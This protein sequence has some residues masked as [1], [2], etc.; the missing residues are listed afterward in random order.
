MSLRQYA[1]LAALCLGLGGWLLVTGG[2]GFGGGVSVGA[3][4]GLVGLAS[5]FL[6]LRKY[7]AARL[8]YDVE[9]WRAQQRTLAGRFW[10]SIALV[11]VAGGVL[12]ALFLAT[13]AAWVAGLVAGLTGL[14]ALLLLGRLTGQ[15]GK[16]F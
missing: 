7:V 12:L 13:G 6:A 14:P 11:V 2:E 3:G 15:L 16:S 8:D 1:N 5:T 4:I 9:F 10:G